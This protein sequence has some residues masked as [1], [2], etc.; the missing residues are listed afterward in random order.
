M[1]KCG[2]RLGSIAAIAVVAVASSAAAQASDDQQPSPE[3][4]RQ[5]VALCAPANRAHR[6]FR[7]E[8]LCGDVSLRVF[9]KPADAV[10][11]WIAAY[12]KAPDAASGCLVID[13]VDAVATDAN[14]ALLKAGVG[15][16][17]IIDCRTARMQ[18][19][20]RAQQR[21]ADEAMAEYERLKQQR[22]EAERKF[23]EQNAA[24]RAEMEARAAEIDRMES[25]AQQPRP[26]NSGPSVSDVL[27]GMGEGM[28][29]SGGAQPTAAQPPSAPTTCDSDFACLYGQ[30]CVKPEG[31]FQGTCAQEVNRFGSPSFTPPRTDSF[32]AG[33]RGNCRFDMDCGVGFYCA[34]S[35]GALSGNCFKR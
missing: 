26:Q 17:A 13:R 28:L 20:I 5:A 16:P 32:N 29:H 35:S 1:P 3:Q 34:K 27:H 25:Q 14:A 15:T 31:Q 21:K 11:H 19:Q 33:Q 24:D 8:L 23:D 6:D 18:A 4:M 12:P 9:D 7:T 22:E 2:A 30:R 10:A